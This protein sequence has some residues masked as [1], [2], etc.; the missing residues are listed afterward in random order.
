MA[1]Y[2]SR[3]ASRL[4]RGVMGADVVPNEGANQWS[5]TKP[6]HIG[7]MESDVMTIHKAATSICR[8][9]PINH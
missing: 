4:V 3:E 8:P 5:G 7:Y 6:T 9:A 2:C 1:D